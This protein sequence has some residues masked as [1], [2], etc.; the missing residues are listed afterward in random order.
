MKSIQLTFKYAILSV[1]FLIL[2]L[3]VAGCEE[4]ASTAPFTGF[5][6][7]RTDGEIFIKDQTSKLWNITHAVEEYGFIP[8][9]FQFGL[10]PTAIRPISD[11]VFLAPGDGG[12]P[13]VAN[14]FL[15]IGYKNSEQ[16]RAYSLNILVHHEIVN[17]QFGDQPVVVAYCPL[18]NLTAVYKRETFGDKVTLSASGWTYNDTFVIFDFE[19]ESLWYPIP[20][21]SGLTCINGIYADRKLAEISSTQLRWADWKREN[22]T[23]LYLKSPE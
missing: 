14:D 11:P 4:E 7:I 15:V 3:L 10:G 21:Q 19:T 16:I 5:E 12:Y 18:V 1:T 6:I 2:G 22:P 23:T 8:E 20:G 17:D 9:S 13:A